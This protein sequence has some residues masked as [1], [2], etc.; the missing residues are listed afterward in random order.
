M[1]VDSEAHIFV[2]SVTV[3]VSKLEYFVERRELPLLV[4]ETER[5]HQAVYGFLPIFARSV[6]QVF[7]HLCTTK[8]AH[9]GLYSP[10]V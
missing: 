7:A 9:L 8:L 3:S 2:I 6:L 5:G 10:D 4:V 1:I